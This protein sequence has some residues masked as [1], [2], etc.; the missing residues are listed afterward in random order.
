[1]IA[2]TMTKADFVS[3]RQAA[4]ILGISR[5]AVWKAI[6]EGRLAAHKVDTFHIIRRSEL[7]KY[8]VDKTMKKM[9]DLRKK[10]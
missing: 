3:I 2:T 10:K 4:E 1:M 8:H 9:G 6:Q 7:S 5:A